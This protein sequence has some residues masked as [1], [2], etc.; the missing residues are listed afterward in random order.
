[1]ENLTLSIKHHFGEINI[2]QKIYL[3]PFIENGKSFESLDST[4]W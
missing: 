3:S 2:I 1:M 4:L